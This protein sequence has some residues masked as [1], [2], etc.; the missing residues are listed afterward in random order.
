MWR[1]GLVNLKKNPVTPRIE[2]LTF[3]FVTV[4]Y[5]MT[6]TPLLD[7]HASCCVS[8]VYIYDSWCDRQLN[9]YLNKQISTLVC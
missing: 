6:L 5:A 7:E 3:R 2:P 9:K 4:E 8:C 1:E